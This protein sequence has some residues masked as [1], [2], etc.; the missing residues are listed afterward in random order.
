MYGTVEMPVA[1]VQNWVGGVE[2]PD[3]ALALP[4]LSL[5]RGVAEEI[6]N[7]IAAG[8]EVTVHEKAINAYGFSGFGYIIIDPDTGVGGYLIEGKGSGGDLI[9]GGIL[10]M[11]ISLLG[12]IGAGMVGALS[13]PL[14][15]VGA[16]LLFHVIIAIAIASISF[17]LAGILES[18]GLTKACNITAGLGTTIM[19]GILLGMVIGGPLAILLAGALLTASISYLMYDMCS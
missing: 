5:S 2:T 3:A 1:A 15:G 19:G 12:F 18:Y 11:I 9:G 10:G 4:K 6:Q 8:K 17:I 7:A 14:A 13:L 16:L